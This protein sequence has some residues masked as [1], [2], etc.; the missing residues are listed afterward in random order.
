MDKA[1]L[2]RRLH[3]AVLYAAA[4]ERAQAEYL[5]CPERKAYEC[6][7]EIA[8]ALHLVGREFSD[9]CSAEYEA[10]LEARL[11]I[12]MRYGVDPKALL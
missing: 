1:A 5:E 4:V 3:E 6:K 8:K 11:R 2:M 10:D 12:A 9:L 7:Q